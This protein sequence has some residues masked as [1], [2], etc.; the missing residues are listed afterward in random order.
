[1]NDPSQPDEPTPP[2]LSRGELTMVVLYAI[3]ALAGFVL[4]PGGHPLLLLPAAAATLAYLPQR[5]VRLPLAHGYVSG[6]QPAFVVL[7]FCVPLNTVPL[8]VPVG[9]FGSTI[10][11]YRQLS[12]R[13]LPM[14]ILDSWYCIAPV[15]ILAHWAPGAAQWT[16]WPVYLAAFTAQFAVGAASPVLFL[17]LERAPINFDKGTVLQPAAIDAVLTP[18]GLAAAVAAGTAPAATVTVLLCVTI[19]IAIL[20]RERMTRLDFQVA[21]LHDPLTNL[22][23]RALFDELLHAAS[24][25]C[26]RTG[27]IAGLLLVDLDDFKHINDHYGHLAGDAVLQAV[28]AR[29]SSVVRDEDTVARFGGDEFAVLLADPTTPAAVNHVAAKV[30]QALSQPLRPAGLG[31]LDVTSSVGVATFGAAEPVAAAFELADQAMYAC[32]RLNHAVAKPAAAQAAVA[33]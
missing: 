30:K 9:I 21:A 29:L 24:R 23:N 20:G 19:L 8:L 10:V 18:I 12:A 26:A 14:A 1:L 33:T 13:R 16:H 22:A 5:V 17:A 2:R 3:A 7:L 11:G 15:L 31:E 28:A 4:L 32:K 25:R 27:S 6:V